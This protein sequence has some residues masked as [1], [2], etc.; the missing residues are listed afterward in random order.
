M[1]SVLRR[2]GLIVTVALASVAAC[3]GQVGALRRQAGSGDDRAADERAAAE[4]SL[5][6]ARIRR[7][8]TAEYDASVKALLG[9]DSIYGAS[10]TPDARQDG[11]TTNDAQR[12]DPVFAIQLEAAAEQL[13][14]SAR[15]KLSELA[16]CSD[17]DPSEGCA[18]IFLTGFATRA[19]RR[20][21]TTREVD[22]LM[23][24]YRA[25]AEGSTFADG[26]EATIG[27]VL[28]SPGFL[29]VT[30]I[31][32]G[33]PSPAVAMTP[34]EIANAMSYLF[35]A[36][37]P[38][39]A[40]L[41]AAE[42]GELGAADARVAEGRRLLSLPGAGAQATRVVEQWLGIDRISQTA[43]DSTVY[44]DFAGLRDAMKREA[45]DF[46]SEVMWKSGGTVSD[47]LSADWTIA[48]PMLATLYR[49]VAAGN[50]VSLAG[51]P[52]RGI[53]NQG[54]FLS[55]YAHASETAPVLRGVAVMRRLACIDVPS[56]VTLNLNIVPPVPDPAKTTRDR[57]GI[58]A[59]DQVC[60]GC[61]QNIDA[62]GFAFENLDGM[63]RA[64]RDENGHPVD[65]STTVS[66]GLD[67]DGTYPESSALMLK[68][69]ASA[70]VRGCFARH[71]F[72]SAVSRSDHE[73]AGA[74][75][76]FIDVWGTL[77]PDQQGS[78][79]EVLLAWVASD[80]FTLR[81]SVP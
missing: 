23:A 15:T 41:A 78:Y 43:K 10:F 35:A 45:D 12:V 1:S 13:A 24:V 7:L 44:P 49:G 25:G 30:E 47:L 16:P 66:V 67:F 71:L 33:N 32:D 11:F 6:P 40:L 26:I 77:A 53:T 73:E 75:Q 58:H 63:G 20:P 21:A 3:N 65:S 28:Q 8:S 59:T 38:D 17:S 79:G 18:R 68:L 52:R 37:P 51:V 74:E 81:R 19:Y 76:S 31:G 39:D 9:I 60:A 55:V 34:H 72:R 4:A 48:D 46:V 80:A 29:Y 27:A 42:A 69:G 70:S 5:L 62:F 2:N 61:H 36:G 56:P 54:A 57:F 64:R 50:R 14:A 22:A